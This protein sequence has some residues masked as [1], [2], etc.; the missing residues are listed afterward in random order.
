M[1]LL[2]YQEEAFVEYSAKLYRNFVFPLITAKIPFI[3]AVN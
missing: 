1:K 2:P 3:K